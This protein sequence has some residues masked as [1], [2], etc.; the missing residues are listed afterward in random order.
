MSSRAVTGLLFV[1]ALACAACARGGFDGR[2]AGD[3][4]G[5]AGD[6]DGVVNSGDDTQIQLPFTA[7]RIDLLAGKENPAG[8]QDGLGTQA[9]FGRPAG[10]ETDGTNLYVA[11]GGSETIRQVSLATGEVTT[12]AGQPWVW[13]TADGVGSAARFN[14]PIGITH[15]AGVLFVSDHYNHTIRRIELATRTVTTFAGTPGVEGSDDGVGTAATLRNPWG[16][17]NDGTYLYVVEYSGHR[18]RRIEIATAVVSQFVGSSVGDQDGFGTDALLGYPSGI[19]VAGDTAFVVDR[20]NQRIK[21]INLPTAEVTSRTSYFDGRPT[22]ITV[23]S[24]TEVYWTHGN[25]LV[26]HDVPSGVMT[27]LAGDLWNSGCHDGIGP[28]AGLNLPEGILLVGSDLYFT[29]TGNHSLR[30]CD[31][32][33]GVVTTTAGR[34]GQCEGTADGVGADAWFK[35]PNDLV[36]DG[37]YLWV[38][39]ELGYTVR[40]VEIA[41]GNTITAAGLA[42]SWGG[43]DGVGGDARFHR[44]AGITLM[45]GMLWIAD[46][47]SQLIRT[48]D[49]TTFEVT[50]IAGQLLV[51][52]ADD[53][54]GAAATFRYPNGIAHDGTHLYI[55]DQDNSTIRR[56]DPVTHEVT[57]LTGIA[58][59]W[60]LDDGPPGV[61]TFARPNRLAY[62]AGSLYVTDTGSAAVR[63]IDL[64]SGETTTFAGSNSGWGEGYVDGP[65]SEARFYWPYGLACDDTALFVADEGCMIRRIDLATREVTTF[66][67]QFG[68]CQDT[69]GP[70]A[71]ASINGAFELEL[72]R[73]TADLFVIG[74][75]NIRRV[76]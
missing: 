74:T 71:T 29:E 35:D 67:G 2:A 69:D 33:T 60:G 13:G 31:P 45:N 51:R 64:S 53:G 23:A 47:D 41:T 27:S 24:A 65:A 40:R 8:H 43:I 56:L 63:R 3:L 72:D 19:A 42:H 39:D 66:A 62:C 7:T 17:A 20:G 5:E 76:H 34:M 4:D 57:T 32:G 55:A 9:M 28:G 46:E 37:E 6:S 1:M 16:I 58:G 30:V 22:A 75:F 50:T 44:P 38:V 52:G 18:I 68:V 59:T 21:E 73:T 26:H 49:P 10:L 15:L 14:G 54:T 70:L 61:A 12:V 36:S 25:K 48:L 11:S